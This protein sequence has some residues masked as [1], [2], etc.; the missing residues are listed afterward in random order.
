[1][2]NQDLDCLP[3]NEWEFFTDNAYY[4]MG[5]VRRVGSKS[6]DES[7]HLF[8]TKQ[9]ERICRLLNAAARGEP[10]PRVLAEPRGDAQHVRIN[11]QDAGYVTAGSAA[12]VEILEAALRGY[13]ERRAQVRARHL[14]ACLDELLADF[15]TATGG[16]PSKTSCLTLMEWSHSRIKTTT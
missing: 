12:D 9:A 15:I 6:L 14:H 16:L 13:A 8:T 7:I 1:M 3:A 4:H 5:C 10:T 11:I 2:C